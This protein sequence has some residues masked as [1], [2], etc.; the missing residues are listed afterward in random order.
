MAQSFQGDILQG[1]TS[2]F[3]QEI[4]SLQ[5]P[6]EPEPDVSEACDCSETS[7]I[8]LGGELFSDELGECSLVR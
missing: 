2:N 7:E 1:F 4:S 6:P 8:E 5:E 3:E